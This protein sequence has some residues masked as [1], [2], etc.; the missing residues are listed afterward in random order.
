MALAMFAGLLRHL[1][2]L[3]MTVRKVIFKK[4]GGE[5]D[6]LR[7]C[8]AE[9]TLLPGSHPYVSYNKYRCVLRESQM[10]DF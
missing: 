1:R 6:W 5:R 4:S 3:A 8:F 7:R 10:N 2:F 9:R